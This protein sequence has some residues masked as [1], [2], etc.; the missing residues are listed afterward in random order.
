MPLDEYFLHIYI[1]PSIFCKYYKVLIVKV[2]NVRSVARYHNMTR[3]QVVD[4][5]PAMEGSCGRPKRGDPP[6]WW[7]GVRLTVPQRKNIT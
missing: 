6:A 5:A 2:L 1:H 7:L 4:R 3:S